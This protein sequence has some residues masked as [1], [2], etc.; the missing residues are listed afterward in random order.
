[1]LYRTCPCVGAASWES[2][3]VQHTAGVLK[4]QRVQ[5]AALR[6]PYCVR[7]SCSVALTF[8]SLTSYRWAAMSGWDTRSTQSFVI[9]CLMEAS[10]D[11]KP[12]ATSFVLLPLSQRAVEWHFYIS[13]IC[14]VTYNT[15]TICQTPSWASQL[16]NVTSYSWLVYIHLLRCLLLS[17]LI[18]ENGETFR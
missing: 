1:M 5:C 17:H 18:W 4:V 13:D 11:T 8:L 9:G 6:N 10:E 12:A 2:S 3:R 14:T 15:I 7:R 16:Y